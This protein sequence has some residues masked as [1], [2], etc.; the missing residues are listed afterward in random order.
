ME[1]K[2]NHIHFVQDFIDNSKIRNYER[3]CLQ[4]I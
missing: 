3:T 1:E 2:K 4:L